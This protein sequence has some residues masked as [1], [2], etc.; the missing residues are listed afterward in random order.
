MVGTNW[1]CI[2]NQLAE[3]SKLR[4]AR[5]CLEGLKRKKHKIKANQG[6]PAKNPLMLKLVFLSRNQEFQL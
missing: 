3:C 1:W 5:G 4:W 6:E 2:E